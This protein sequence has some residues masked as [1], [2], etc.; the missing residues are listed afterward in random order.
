MVL[1]FRAPTPVMLSLTVSRNLTI[2]QL[3]KV[4]TLY[5]AELDST[6]LQQI[7]KEYSHLLERPK[8]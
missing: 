8:R 3:S 5:E 4:K 1:S 6:L 7:K 2:E